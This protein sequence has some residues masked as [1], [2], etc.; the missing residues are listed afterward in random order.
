M[1]LIVWKFQLAAGEFLLPKITPRKCQNSRVIGSLRVPLSIAF[2]YRDLR[3]SNSTF[4]FS[5]KYTI[6]VAR[7]QRLWKSNWND[8]WSR[9]FRLAQQI[10]LI[11]QKTISRG[12]GSH[13]MNKSAR[14]RISRSFSVLGEST[15]PILEYL[16]MSC[17]S[18]AAVNW[19]AP[20]KTVPK[21][22]R[23]KSSALYWSLRIQIFRRSK[24]N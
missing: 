2:H 9:G 6:L 24:R 13:S 22:L 8:W 7:P 23:S 15:P 17:F 14:Q 18:Y 4:S 5:L 11:D 16:I 19:S 21:Y 3:V 1:T 20:H 12:L 10:K